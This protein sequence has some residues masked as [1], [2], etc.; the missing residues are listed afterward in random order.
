MP[1]GDPEGY[2]VEDLRAT[3]QRRLGS[4]IDERMAEIGRAGLYN[5]G[6]QPRY[7]RREGDVGYFEPAG[8]GPERAV[9]L[10]SAPS[11]ARLVE[12]ADAAQQQVQAQPGGPSASAQLADRGGVVPGPDPQLAQMVRERLPRAEPP[13]PVPA[14]VFDLDAAA[15]RAAQLE[16]QRA[17]QPA[18]AQPA[19]QPMT[20]G[21]PLQ[22]PV[23]EMDPNRPGMPPMLSP[24]WDTRIGAEAMSDTADLTGGAGR[25]QAAPGGAP[26]PGRPGA[27]MPAG[28]GRMRAAGRPAAPAAPLTE[29]QRN[30]R[31]ITELTQRPA[32]AAPIAPEDFR[33][34]SFGERTADLIAG[35]ERLERERAALGG[36]RAAEEQDALEQAQ[37]RQTRLETERQDAMRV[38]QQ[39]YDT[40][41]RRLQESNVDPDRYWANRGGAVGRIGGAIAVALGAAGAAMTGG[42]NTALAIIQNEINQDIE[43]QRAGMERDAQGVQAARSFLDLTRA[44]FSD[45]AA[46]ED[47]ARA[48]AWETVA[49]RVAQQEAGLADGEARQRASALRLQAEQEAAAAAA[50]AQRAELLA[51]LELRERMATVST[52]EANAM[53]AARRAR[54]GGGSPTADLAR[55]AQLA[56]QLQQAGIDPQQAREMVGL[57]DARAAADQGGPTGQEAGQLRALDAQLSTVRSMVPETGD[58]PGFGLWDRNAPAWLRTEQGNELFAQLRATEELFGRLQSGGVIGEEEAQNF[59]NIIR[60]SMGEGPDGLRRGLRIVRRMLDARSNRP[61]TPSQQEQLDAASQAAGFQ[62]EGG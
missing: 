43:A 37:R 30:E 31:L 47:A 50:N 51:E 26:A 3:R 8:G 58:I 16:A 56:R 48:M 21:G 55:R 18:P 60:G 10:P 15:Q 40:A 2:T 41:V 59:Q 39:R 7:V 28:A 11:F 5:D 62:P 4:R 25:P 14:D 36:R 20:V 61:R 38:A 17:A 12:E 57:G 27:P 6:S 1:P 54:G 24:S 46:A 9:H 19:P 32:D 53:R 35:N 33:R 13:A 49:R 42:P 44:E 23:T 45:R 34:A 52:A 22:I 29:A